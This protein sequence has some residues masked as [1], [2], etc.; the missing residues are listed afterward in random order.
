MYMYDYLFKVIMIGDTNAGKTSIIHN[1]TNKKYG[2]PDTPTIGIDFASFITN[3]KYDDISNN[4]YNEDICIKS[5]IWDTAGQ[6][7][8]K[9]IIHSYYNNI[10]GCIFVYDVTDIKSFNMIDVWF[11]DFYN[12]VQDVNKVAIMLVANKI[13]LTNKRVITF[14]QGLNL[15]NK[16]NMIYHESTINDANT[17]N[18]L[19]KTLFHDIYHNRDKYNNKGIKTMDDII[20]INEYKSKSK[21]NKNRNCCC[22]S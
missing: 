9:S 14:K 21:S 11:Q 18:L 6:E 17:I 15:A 2:N 8:F 3:I 5:Q 1:I 10:A 7:K 19:F 16:Y 22:I 20:N 4:I 12:N 13:D